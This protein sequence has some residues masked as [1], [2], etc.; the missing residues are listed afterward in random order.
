MQFIPITGITLWFIVAAT[1]LRIFPTWVLS[2]TI[3]CLI[4]EA[5]VFG[6]LF[7]VIRKA[8]KADAVVRCGKCRKSCSRGVQLFEMKR[9]LPV[10]NRDENLVVCRYCK[11]DLPRAWKQVDTFTVGFKTFSA[12]RREQWTSEKIV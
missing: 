3:A 1:Y 6:V 9:V 4:L 12:G 7:F 10:G 11:E 2:A 8:E 5:A